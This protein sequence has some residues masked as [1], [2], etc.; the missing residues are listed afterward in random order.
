MLERSLNMIISILG[1]L[2][3][4]G[5][6]VPIAPS[7]PIDR[8]QYILENN[9]DW[10][11][12]DNNAL[13][14]SIV[15]AK[16]LV[17]V[18]SLDDIAHIITREAT[19]NLA[20]ATSSDGLAYVLYT[21]GTTGKSKGVQISHRSLVNHMC[22]MKDKFKFDDTDII[23]QKTPF[24]FDASVWELFIPILVGGK[25]IFASQY[26]H[27][28][29]PDMISEIQKYGITTLQLVPSILREL[30]KLDAL[31]ACC[32]LRQ[33]FS[34]GELLSSEIKQQFFHILKNVEL[35]NLYGPTEAT[36]EVTS[37][38][39]VNSKEDIDFNIIGKPINN[40]HLYILDRNLEIVPVGVSGE[41]YIAGDCLSIGYV[42][43]AKLT[44]EKFIPDK[45][46]DNK[47]D[48]LYKTGDLARWLPS[49]NIEIIGRT[50]CQVKI[51]GFRI[52]LSEIENNI[53][54]HPNI[55]QCAVV[56]RKD[57]LGF[58]FLVA[59]LEADNKVN[60]VNIDTTKDFLKEK[61]PKYMIPS[62]FV[63]LKHLP[64]T[65]HGK[66]DRRNLPSPDI[67]QI[68]QSCNYIKP[69][70]IDEIK[71][72]EIWKEI[73]ELDSIGVEDDFFSL[74][75]H[76]L[77][78]LQLLTRIENIFNVKINIKDFVN[79]S[80]ISKLSKFI[81]NIR[82]S[83]KKLSAKKLNIVKSEFASPIV[84]LRKNGNRSP[85]FL[86][87]PVGGTIFWYIPLAKLLDVDHPI[88]AIQDPGLIHKD[89]KLRS[90]EDMATFYLKFIKEIQP[91]GP[92]LIGGASFGSTVAIEIA[93]QLKIVNEDTIFI[94]LLDGWAFYPDTLLDPEIFRETM[95]RQYTAL[96]TKFA[97]S[98][99]TTNAKEL[100]NLQHYRLN[101]LWNY[102]MD[103]VTH[104]LVLFKSQ[105]LLPVFKTIDSPRNH[106]GNYVTDPIDVHIVPGNHETMF[107][108]PNV[109]ILANKLKDAINLV[110][111]N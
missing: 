26:A 36:I 90:I 10:A 14:K 16:K 69:S 45:F 3:T 7:H 19:D 61:L 46:S 106:W 17:N 65:F 8:I 96:R 100:L 56:A 74:G 13:T 103:T 98:G 85:L 6:Y 32:S 101:M 24:T 54:L 58:D 70:T 84:P 68:R 60:N 86:I 35:H 77:S 109:Q 62:M 92:Y 64:L 34:G 66:V 53:L 72:A 63:F 50:D 73:L 51:R 9:C 44:K 82:K 27:T 80:T 75:G 105:E 99:I 12:V 38:T 1:I 18:I 52:E 2:K 42:N 22:W 108:P 67:N 5:A 29:P 41:L 40:T 28:S 76:S 81:S 23:L 11:I 102:K 4:G 104:R 31:K 97:D 49:G 21:S 88:Y 55:K 15:I 37:H 47:S 33:I 91:N 43:N 93:K 89:I 107:Q 59:Y 79:N 25:L 94:P 111:T 71:I 48:K 39:C 30:L 87:H 57:S 78:F 20:A 83:Q 110:E 95:E